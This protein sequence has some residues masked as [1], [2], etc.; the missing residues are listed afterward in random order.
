MHF[1][2]Q[3]TCTRS[4]PHHRPPS[5]DAARTPA[6]GGYLWPEPKQCA[7]GRD[8]RTRKVSVASS[9]IMHYLGTSHAE[10]TGDLHSVNKV[11]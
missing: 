8:D 10:A 3:A 6:P 4:R 7:L 11:I 2:A 1:A 9:P 5:S